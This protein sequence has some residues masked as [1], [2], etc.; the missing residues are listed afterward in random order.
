ME[1]VIALFGFLW[2]AIGRCTRVDIVYDIIM[3]LELSFLD[4]TKKPNHFISSLVS[5]NSNR[6]IV[7]LVHW[8]SYYNSS[9]CFGATAVDGN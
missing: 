7:F 4:S 1:H 5:C 3:F 8:K 2:L 6:K 9:K